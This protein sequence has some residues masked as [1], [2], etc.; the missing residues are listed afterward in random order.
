MIDR[1]DVD[2]SDVTR[3]LR[4]FA[5]R[6]DNL[7]MPFIAEVL[8][9][10]VDDLIQSEGA[11]GTQG[12]WK[13]FAQSTLERHPRRRGGKLLQDKGVLANFQARTGPDFAEVY[14]PAPYAEWHVTGTRHMPKRNPLAIDLTKVT[15]EI[16]EDVLEEIAS[17]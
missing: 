11:E 4:V 7:N 8:S 14:S 17:P 5:R 15:D 13:P 10:A 1:V 2:V 3:A 12:P 6:A 16:A 9:T